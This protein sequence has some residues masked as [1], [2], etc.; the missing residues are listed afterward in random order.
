MKS[1]GMHFHPPFVTLPRHKRGN[2]VIRLKG[3]MRRDA[4]EYGGRFASHLVLNEPGRPDLYNQDFDFWFPGTSRFTIW[5]AYMTT[6]RKAFWD[7]VSDIA[8][9]RADA[10]LT[11]EQ[12]ARHA[13]LEFVPAERS[14]TGKVLFYTLAPRDERFEQLGG[15]TFTEQWHKLESEI[16]RDE[17]PVIY[18]SFSLDRKYA[19]GIGLKI[20]MDVPF[21][22]QAAIEAAMDRFFAVGETDWVAP[23]P[24]PRAALPSESEHEALAGIA[25]HLV[26]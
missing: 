26:A 14:A 20:V 12:R 2:A 16:A 15:L 23:D 1:H 5:N 24:V 25:G 3:R 17:P 18:E 10:L 9:A 6:A 11:P 19:Y 7:K 4:A 21:I 22:N 8:Y 13:K